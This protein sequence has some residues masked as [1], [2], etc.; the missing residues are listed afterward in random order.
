MYD[1]VDAVLRE[2]ARSIYFSF[3]QRRK[4]AFDELNVV[5]NIRELYEELDR[6]ARKAFGDIFEY[7]YTMEA[8]EIETRPE[9][10]LDRFLAQPSAVIKRAWSSETVR[11]RDMLTESLIATRGRPNEYDSAAKYWSRMVGWFAI[12]VADA[13]LAQSRAD[14]GA[15]L[16]MWQAEM[17][18]R[19]CVTCWSLDGRIFPLNA[20]PVKPHPNC[21]CWT[22][23]IG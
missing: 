11:K 19:T 17:D 9:G 4:L 20:V 23:R 15:K 18:D 8:P 7:Y 14:T 3:Q 12:D 16:V 6:S 13:A 22:V 21:R 5:R 10:W 1:Y 2:L